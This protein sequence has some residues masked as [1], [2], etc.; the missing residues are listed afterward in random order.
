MI[1]C[2]G[3]DV[4]SN[5]GLIFHYFRDVMSYAMYPAVFEEFAQHFNTFGDVSKLSSEMVS[6][7]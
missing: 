5:I 2:T 7:E 4:L 6:T 3:L 1:N